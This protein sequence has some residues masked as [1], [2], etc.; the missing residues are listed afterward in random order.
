MELHYQIAGQYK[1]DAHLIGSH[2]IKSGIELYGQGIPKEKEKDFKKPIRD[3]NLP[4]WIIPDTQG[5]LQ[6]ILHSCRA[7]EFCKDIIILTSEKTSKNYLDYLNE[8]DYDHIC[9]GKDHV[10]IEKCLEFLYQKYECKKILTDTGKILGN[11]LLNKGLI[12]E[13]SLLI[14]PVIVGEKGYYIF[15]DI[16]SNIELDCI[17]DKKFDGGYIWLVFKVKK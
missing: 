5:I 6:G 9:F 14:H 10:N 12:N 13:I 15:D 16:L 1:P 4:Y 7:F 17:K 8:R 3:T 2:T 11:L